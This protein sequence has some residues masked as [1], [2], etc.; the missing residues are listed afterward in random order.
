M[1]P[2]DLLLFMACVE[3]PAR[4]PALEDPLWKIRFG[5]SAL[6]DPLWRARSCWEERGRGH[7]QNLSPSPS[8]G[9]QGA[10]QHAQNLPD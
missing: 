4:I 1:Q 8:E 9:E 3:H 7:A 5:G 6:E 2:S 10:G